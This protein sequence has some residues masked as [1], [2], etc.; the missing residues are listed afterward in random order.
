MTIC[1]ITN[2]QFEGPDQ[3]ANIMK[4]RGDPI[5]RSNIIVVLQPNQFYRFP[6]ILAWATS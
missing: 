1:N 6:A 4:T 5:A 3:T 2:P